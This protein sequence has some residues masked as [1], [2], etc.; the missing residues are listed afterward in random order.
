MIFL[1]IVKINQYIFFS[2]WFL[3]FKL[4]T[5]PELSQLLSLPQDV[6][7]FRYKT[8]KINKIWE[9]LRFFEFLDHF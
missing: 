8:L 2:I 9:K 5:T 7:H 1:S 3:I 4:S 6:A